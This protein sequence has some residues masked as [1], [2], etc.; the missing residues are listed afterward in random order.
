M[1][2]LKL[3]TVCFMATCMVACDVDKTE[4]GESPELDVDVE[5]ESG[6]LPEYDVDWANVDV[7]TRTKTVTVPK[8]VIVQEEE[9]VE[10]PYIDVTMPDNMEGKT[11]RTIMV[12]AEVSGEMHEMD[13]EKV[14]ATQNK[15]IVISSLET[16]DEQLEQQTVR[17]SDQIMINAPEGL[18]IDKYII[19]QK[20]TGEFNNQYSYV[21]NENDI[22]NMIADAQLIY[23][24]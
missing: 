6:E 4:Q 22:S 19:G 20:P 15:L 5:A 18:V 8:V 14:Y 23:E 1:K 24:D 7:A 12:E 2:N 11:E 13:I 10:V 16:T 9:Q 21:G 3:L 17:V